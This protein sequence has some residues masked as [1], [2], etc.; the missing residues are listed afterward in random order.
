MRTP[1]PPG[2]PNVLTS[3]FP[4]L[5]WPAQQPLSR[6]HRVEHD[7]AYFATG[8]DGRFNPPL[9]EAGFGT[10]YLSSHP[11]GAFVETL[12]RFRYIS[13]AMINERVLAEVYMPS[14]LR[15][16]DLTNP[17]VLGKFGI[18]NDLSMGN[19]ADAYALAQQWALRLWQAGFSGLYYGARRDV[20]L[21]TRSVALVRQTRGRG[22]ERRP[23]DFAPP[24]RDRRRDGRP[25]R[26]RHRHGASVVRTGPVRSPGDGGKAVRAVHVRVG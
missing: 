3:E 5:I 26:V 16:A 1:P 4:T 10:L 17:Q 19:E 13:Q 23:V 21:Q 14:D 6:V 24:E 2:D 22:R 12:G 20:E 7:T 8:Q 11:R 25:L 9:P 18:S 15:L